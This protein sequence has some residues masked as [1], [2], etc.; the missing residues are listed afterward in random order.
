MRQGVDGEAHQE[1]EPAGEIPGA[2]GDQASW[3]K[4]EEGRPRA[5]LYYP[6]GCQNKG[7]A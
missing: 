6:R 1:E 3:S 7:E 5:V 4:N 2:Q